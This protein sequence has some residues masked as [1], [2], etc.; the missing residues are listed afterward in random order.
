MMSFLY[1]DNILDLLGCQKI[2]P[3]KVTMNPS[4]FKNKGEARNENI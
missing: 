2:I 1:G 4:I 3:H